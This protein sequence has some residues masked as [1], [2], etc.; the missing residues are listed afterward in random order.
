MEIPI[1][2]YRNQVAS[3]MTLE[4]LFKQRLL[5]NIAEDIFLE[6]FLKRI[7]R[8]RLK[9]VT[10]KGYTDE[11]AL[12]IQKYGDHEYILDLIRIIDAVNGNIPNLMDSKTWKIF[13]EFINLANA[14]LVHI[15]IDTPTWFTIPSFKNLFKRSLAKED[16]GL[17]HFLVYE[18]KYIPYFIDEIQQT[19]PFIEAENDISHKRSIMDLGDL[20]YNFMQDM[21]NYG[22]LISKDDLIDYL[23]YTA[24][25]SRV[26]IELDEE[27][28]IIDNSD[29]IDEIIGVLKSYDIIDD[30]N[31]NILKNVNI[32]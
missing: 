2:V 6:E 24:M 13:I 9:L 8:T 17:F 15:R 14:T 29:D 19:N 12:F 7:P 25:V 10:H 18:P 26:C 16:L 30:K 21:N 11:V 27:N 23:R 3:Y 1:D 32:R 28:F 31:I 20:I 22:I 5:G 4:D